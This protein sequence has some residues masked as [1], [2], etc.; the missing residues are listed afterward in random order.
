MLP[1]AFLSRNHDLVSMLKAQD[2][3]KHFVV[4]MVIIGT[5]L[6]TVHM[7]GFINLFPIE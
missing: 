1:S 3:F 2:Y 6:S 5:L 7:N 4:A